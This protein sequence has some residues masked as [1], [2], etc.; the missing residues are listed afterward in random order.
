MYF[1]LCILVAVVAKQSC[2]RRYFR[3]KPIFILPFPVTVMTLSW[4]G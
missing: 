1:D 2:L 4:I 3:N